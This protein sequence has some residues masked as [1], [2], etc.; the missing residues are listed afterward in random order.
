MDFFDLLQNHA[1]VFFLLLTRVSGVFLIAPFF[2]SINI[3]AYMRVGLTLTISAVLFPVVDSAAGVKAPSSQVTAP[4]SQRRRMLL[5]VL[6]F[7]AGF[8]V[9]FVAYTVIGGAASVFFLEW[10]DLITR[11]T[12]DV[13]KMSTSVRWALRSWHAT[14]LGPLPMALQ[15]PPEDPRGTAGLPPG[16]A[17]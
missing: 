3:P 1:A 13:G 7:I 14:R 5:G 8:T 10:G 11:I 17:A 16:E 9:V 4:A 12:A 15:N 2:G 6:L